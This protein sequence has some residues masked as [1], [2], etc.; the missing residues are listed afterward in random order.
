MQALVKPL[1]TLSL[2]KEVVR[3]GRVLHNANLVPQN[4]LDDAL[5][6]ALAA[7]AGVDVLVSWNFRHMVNL[8]VKQD[9]PSYWRRNVTSD[10]TR[11]FRLTSIERAKMEDPKIQEDPVIEELRAIREKISRITEGFSDEELIA[12]YKAK[13][14][15]ARTR[16]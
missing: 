12:W 7:V 1:T 8:K 13:A 5:H 10:N 9:L 2:N 11:S 6:L 4:K 15:K 3:L 14:E 16:V